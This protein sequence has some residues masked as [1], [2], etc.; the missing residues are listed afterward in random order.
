MLEERIELGSAVHEEGGGGIRRKALSSVAFF[1]RLF[2]RFTD[3][4]VE[5]VCSHN[6]FFTKL[7]PLPYI[8]DFLGKITIQMPK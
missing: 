1:A 4:V 2:D 5:G 3:F 6:F 8:L 7:P